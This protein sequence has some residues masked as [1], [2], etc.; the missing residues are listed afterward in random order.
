[1]DTHAFVINLKSATARRESISRQ[2]ETLCIPYTIITA[3]DGRALSNEE[4]VSNYDE[5]AAIKKQ[6]KL[7]RAEIATSLSHIS[8]YQTIVR[9]KLP[10]ALVLEDDA[11]LGKNVSEILGLLA[12]KIPPDECTV[13]LL[14]HVKWYSR[15]GSS[16]LGE[17]HLLAKPVP[18]HAWLAHGYFITQAA[19][20]RLA[21]A[22][23]PISVQA[24]NWMQFQRETSV[25]IYNIVPYCIGL[26][27]LAK[28]SA[29]EAERAGY[30][31]EMKRRWK[32]QLRQRL[33]EPFLKLARVL[34][35]PI[36]GKSRQKQ[37]W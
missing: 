20:K 21:G 8:V 13:I 16:K 34:T 7:T 32:A 10:Y 31:L 1:M 28:E 17:S 14:T 11:L 26:G 36:T 29:L 15:R 22:L 37:T 33:I 6:R 5:G 18:R 30:E 9:E 27:E 3:V 4:I 19:A 2:L 25:R 35:R 23:L 24:D 12:R